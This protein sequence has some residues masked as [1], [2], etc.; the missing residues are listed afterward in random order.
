MSRL[1]KRHPLELQERG[2]DD[3]LA[4]HT[5]TSILLDGVDWRLCDRAVFELDLLLDDLVGLLVERGASC[6]VLVGVRLIWD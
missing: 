2:S 1:A 4:A 6:L 3:F 5:P